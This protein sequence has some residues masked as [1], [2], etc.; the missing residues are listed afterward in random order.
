MLVYRDKHDVESEY[1]NTLLKN[2]I[3]EF[4]FDLNAKVVHIRDEEPEEPEEEEDVEDDEQEKEAEDD[5]QGKEAEDDE[6]YSFLENSTA[7]EDEFFASKPDSDDERVV[8]YKPPTVSEPRGFQ[9][10]RNRQGVP[11]SL[12]TNRKIDSPK[13]PG[14]FRLG[15]KTPGDFR[16]GD[17]T[18]GDS[19]LG[20]KPQM[21]LIEKILA[22]KR[23]ADL[24]KTSE[25]E[26]EKPAPRVSN[27]SGRKISDLK[28]LKSR[29]VAERASSLLNRREFIPHKP[30][31]IDENGVMRSHYPSNSHRRPLSEQIK[32]NTN[33]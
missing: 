31:L 25:L 19:R 1:E 21:S 8:S 29:A 15:D 9:L 24:A 22:M 10:I 27:S 18:P 2:E 28:T 30:K 13:T 5:E 7:E 33:Q 3:M 14:D 12:I 20:N 23:E 17:K 26:D 32:S 4:F 11:F 6:D 16:L